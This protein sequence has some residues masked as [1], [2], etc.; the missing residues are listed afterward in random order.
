MPDLDMRKT[1]TPLGDVTFTEEDVAKLLKEIN[2]NK[3]QGPDLL[4]PR[5]LFE[6]RQQIVRPF[7]MLFRKSADNAILPSEWKEADIT[8][9]CKNKGSKHDTNNYRPV[10]LT[11]VICKLLEKLIRKDIINHMKANNLFSIY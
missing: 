8:P 2:V 9:I 10:S 3:S 5:L 4:H 6:A 1:M 11:S 7:Y